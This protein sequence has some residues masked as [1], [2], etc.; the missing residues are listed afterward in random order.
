MELGSAI[1]VVMATRL[2]L[3]VST[4][5]CIVGSTAGVGLCTGDIKAINWGMVLWIYCDWI[6]T[7]PVT[8]IISGCLMGIIINAPQ[9]G[10]AV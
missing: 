10:H 5:Q 4:T 1:T 9:W 2:A 6:I 7:L 3:P 8:G